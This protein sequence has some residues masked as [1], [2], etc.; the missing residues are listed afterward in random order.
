MKHIIFGTGPLGRATMNALLARGEEVQMVNRSG[1]MPN[2]PKQVKVVK[3]DA[4]NLESANQAARG[5]SVVYNCTAPEYSTKLWTTQL[6]IL[7]SNI[8]ESAAS[9][10]AKLVIGDNLYMYD[11]I[12]INIH[13]NLAMQSSTG[14]GKARITSAQQMLEAHKKGLVEVAFARG[15]DFF[16]AYATN[17]SQFG[18]RVIPPML[19]GK[20]AQ[21]LGNLEIPHSMTYIKDFGTAIAMVAAED[22]AYGQ[23]W[24]VPNAPAISRRAMLEQIAQIIGQPLKV[25]IMPKLLMSALGLFVAP[26]REVSEMMYQFEQPYIV[27]HNK[28]VQKF[29]D[30]HTPL[31]TALEETIT[32]FRNPETTLIKTTTQTVS[33]F[34]TRTSITKN[35]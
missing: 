3:C 28:F 15:A 17:Q 20:P 33:S 27:N 30:I 9:A 18:S 31:E 21:M 2:I 5:A 24:H 7:W 16:G 8:L 4:Y 12:G 1:T 14:K 10:N 13:E 35:S 11:Q 25:Q 32:W 34:G 23:A 6:P 29:G 22:S 19:H 26:L